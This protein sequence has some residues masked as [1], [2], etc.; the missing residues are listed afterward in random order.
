MEENIADLCGGWEAELEAYLLAGR[1]KNDLMN[2]LTQPVDEATP[3]HHALEVSYC[4]MSSTASRFVTAI[5]LDPERVLAASD[6]I[7][8]ECMRKIVKDKRSFGVPSEVEVSVK[9]KTHL[10]VKVLPH[11]PVTDRE[12]VPKSEDVGLIIAFKGE[13]RGKCM[14]HV[15][16]SCFVGV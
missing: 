5:L 11:F 13:M 16:S 15:M 6:A 9:A 7:V 12:T 4:D 3:S 10:R 1:G 14:V 2:I 8:V